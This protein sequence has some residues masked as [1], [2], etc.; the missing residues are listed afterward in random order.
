MRISLFDE[1]VAGVFYFACVPYSFLQKTTGPGGLATLPA[2][3]FLDGS[4]DLLRRMILAQEVIECRNCN[5]PS[6]TDP[7]G[8]QAIRSGQVRDSSRRHAQKPCGLLH[9]DC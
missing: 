6:A 5:H 4:V 8:G 2:Q 1:S 3:T 9:T 7:A